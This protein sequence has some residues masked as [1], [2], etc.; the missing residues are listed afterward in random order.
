MTTTLELH[1][2]DDL[3]RV[4]VAFDNHGLRDHRLRVHLPLPQ[5]ASS[6]VAE[7]AFATVER[8]LTAEGGPTE[9]GL[10]TY[11]SR[12][13][14]TAGGLTVAHEGL[15]EYELVDLDDAATTAGALAITLVRATG[16]LSQGPMATRPLPAGPLTPM[17]GP[18]SQHRVEARFA[19]QLGECDPYA[20]VDD[21]LLPLLVTRGGGAAASGAP[22][23]Q[24]LSV[25]GA[26]VSAITREAGGLLVRV[27]NPSARPDDRHHR[28]TAR[29]AA[30]PPGPPAPALRGHLRARALADRDRVAR[31]NPR[32]TRVTEVTGLREKW[33]HRVVSFGAEIAQS[34]TS[35]PVPPDH[36]RWEPYSPSKQP[37]MEQRIEGGRHG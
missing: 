34:G 11:P 1:A 26:E 19:I 8:G 13:F 15:L 12:R 4:H 36:V 18:Q 16:M 21:A 9:Q 23:G 2:G 14:V 28:G 31:L 22:E 24:A 37:P 3:V 35:D 17:E 5:R 6:S 33:S 32:A 30:R 29:L 27:F 25:T 7:C 10:A 20:V